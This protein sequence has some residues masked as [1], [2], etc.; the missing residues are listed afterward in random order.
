MLTLKEGSNIMKNYLIFPNP[1]FTILE[2]N[3]PML[4]MRLVSLKIYFG[5]CV[6]KDSIIFYLKFRSKFPIIK[7]RHIILAYLQSHSG[8]NNKG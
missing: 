5:Q 6:G 8:F 7:H 1:D 3:F 4:I 2:F